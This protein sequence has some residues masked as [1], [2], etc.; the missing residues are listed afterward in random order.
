M[1]L[2]VFIDDR[3]IIK[4]AIRQIVDPERPERV[5]SGHVLVVAASKAEAVTAAAAVTAFPEHVKLC[6]DVAAEWWHRAFDAGIADLDTP[7]VLVTP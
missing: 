6:R 4:P 7:T 5:F 3:A 1:G 2:K